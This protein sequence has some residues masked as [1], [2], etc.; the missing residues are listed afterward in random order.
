M[1]ERLKQAVLKIQKIL[2]DD[3]SRLSIRFL[4]IGSCFCSTPLSDPASRRRL[5][6]SLS[7]HLHQ[8]VKRTSTSKLSNMLA[9]PKKSPLLPERATWC[10]EADYFPT[11]PWSTPTPVQKSQ[12]VVALCVP[13]LPDVISVK[14]ELN[15]RLL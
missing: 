3:D 12:P 8:V 14:Y 4:F 15:P 7:L 9:T 5:C 10:M 6:A 2:A 11:K 1:C 13:Q